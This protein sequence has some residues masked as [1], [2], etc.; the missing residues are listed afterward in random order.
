VV[1]RFAQI[2][3]KLLLAVDGYRYSGN[4]FDRRDVLAGLQER[5]PSLQRT[6]VLPYLDADPDLSRLRKAITWEELRTAGRGADLDFD[7]VTF[8]HPL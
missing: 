6:V 3:P 2:E 5:M 4:D 1:D 8:E 7:T